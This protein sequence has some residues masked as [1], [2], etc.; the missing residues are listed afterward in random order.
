MK[1]YL[2]LICLCQIIVL[3]SY[4]QFSDS[5]KINI[6][7]I[8]TIASGDYQ[9]L[10][11][12]S[13]KFGSIADQKSDISSY[14][15]F[16][17]R[18]TF[19]LLPRI[20][21]RDSG[22]YIQY[23]FS[24]INNRDFQ[25]T[26][27]QQGYIK[28]G[29]QH[30]EIRAGRFEEIIGEVDPEL[31]SGS[32]GI[33]GNALPIPKIGFSV[34]EFTDLPFT[35][36][37]LQFKGLFSHGWLGDNRF[38]NDA[39]LHE[40]IFY[41]SLGKKRLKV[42]GGVQHYAAWGGNRSDFPNKLD[43]DWEGFLNVL[44]VKEAD[45][46]S[47]HGGLDPEDLPPDAIRPNKAG[48]HRGSVEFGFEWERENITLKG[49]NQTPFDMGIGISIKNID[50]LAGLS[51]ENKHNGIFRRGLLEYIYTNQMTDWVPNHR[52][53]Y[54]NNGVYK[55]GWEYENMIIGTPLF[56]NRTRASY[57]FPEVESYD[58]REP[59]RTIRGND[60]I[61]NNRIQGVHLGV[62]LAPFPRIT[63]KTMVSLVRNYGP[64]SPF[65]PYKDQL[66][67]IQEINY[68]SKS[69]G[70]QIVGAIALDYGELTKNIGLMLGI[71]WQLRSMKVM[72]NI[73]RY[74]AL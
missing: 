10:W 24:L 51:I 6:G 59:N 35:N 44:L 53:S 12:V 30:W 4:G 57:Y 36:G 40:K 63:T 18:H 34:K 60:N 16:Q 32:F 61:I 38:M 49:Y 64:K 52:E 50:R 66:Y 13:N 42:F 69:S 17:N 11:I 2:V 71:E 3:K 7:T 65:L 56:T 48:D 5:L 20:F 29:Y 54:Y 74:N 46:G 73:N 67:S 28:A 15:D 33:S 27:F 23:G 14:L 26:L 58:W 45:D 47:V 37:W 39:Y 70:I 1:F 43:R 68:H 72:N 21:E 62:I 19:N 55:T 25:S 22:A 9:P 8:F 31:S 41:M